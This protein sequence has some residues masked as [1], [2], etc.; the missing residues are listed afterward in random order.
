MNRLHHMI[1]FSLVIWT[2]VIAVN[3]E[4]FGFCIAYVRCVYKID[5][6]QQL[7]IR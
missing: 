1:L 4:C 3:G 5:Y 2:S 7:R 6:H